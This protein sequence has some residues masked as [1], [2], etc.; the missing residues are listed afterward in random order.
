MISLSRRPG[1]LRLSFLWN[2]WLWMKPTHKKRNHAIKTFVWMRKASLILQK[3]F[4]IKI[5]EKS[6]DASL[7][8]QSHTSVPKILKKYNNLPTPLRPIHSKSQTRP[9]CG[10][11]VCPS[12]GD[13]FYHIYNLKLYSPF[14]GLKFIKNWPF[15]RAVD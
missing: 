1:F 2:L 7:K 3:Y 10:V 14:F 12:S 4:E 11:G 5:L 6:E 13:N 8:P 9:C 15:C